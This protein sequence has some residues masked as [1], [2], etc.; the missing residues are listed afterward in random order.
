MQWCA[1]YNGQHNKSTKIVENKGMGQTVL[2]K[3]KW[4]ENS[5]Y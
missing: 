2:N 1:S 3:F 4:K 5:Q